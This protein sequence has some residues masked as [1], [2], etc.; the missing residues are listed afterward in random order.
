MG[1][2]H[3]TVLRGLVAVMTRKLSLGAANAARNGDLFLAV[4]DLQDIFI[5]CNGPFGDDL[6]VDG[7]CSH[8]RCLKRLADLQKGLLEILFII[9][10]KGF[11]H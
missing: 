1:T 9:T 7:N 5:G 2:E 6:P 8:Y 10:R 4:D 11:I 3:E